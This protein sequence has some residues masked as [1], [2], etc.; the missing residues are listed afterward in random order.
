MPK[1]SECAY[2][3]NGCLPAVGKPLTC[4]AALAMGGAWVLDAHIL[5]ARSEVESV[6]AKMSCRHASTL[7][8]LGC[9]LG[10]PVDMLRGHV[11][12]GRCVTI[13]C[14]WKLMLLACPILETWDPNSTC[15][16]KNFKVVWALAAMR[17][18]CMKD[19]S[20]PS[21]PACFCSCCIGCAVPL[22]C[23]CTALHAVAALV[24]SALPV[25]LLLL[26]TVCMRQ[27][28]TV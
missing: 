12:N 16:C 24:P 28:L 20:P 9:A 26:A 1:S 21:L 2:D 6:L 3:R 23:L 5:E 14:S 7:T 11:L 27:H 15:S 8:R 4:I 18:A 22:F 13:T 10:S 17:M 19:V 25:G